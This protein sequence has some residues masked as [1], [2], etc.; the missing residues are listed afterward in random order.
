MARY[1]GPD[2][3]KTGHCHLKRAELGVK[4]GKGGLCPFSATATANAVGL[5]RH[6]QLRMETLV[7]AWCAKTCP[8]FVPID[9][10]SYI[11]NPPVKCMT[12]WWNCPILSPFCPLWARAVP[13]LSRA[14][15]WVRSGGAPSSALRAVWRRFVA[16]PPHFF[17]QICPPGPDVPTKPKY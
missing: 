8:A 11:I 5:P 10:H 4:R 7:G 15:F 2:N 3:V 17:R 14:P 6:Q 1:F 16:C 12:T 9:I 13:I